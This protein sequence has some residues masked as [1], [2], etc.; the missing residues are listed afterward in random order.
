MDMIHIYLVHLR[1]HLCMFLVLSWHLDLVYVLPPLNIVLLPSTPHNPNA[2][3]HTQFT[4]LVR[5][6]HPGFQ[7]TV[8]QLNDPASHPS[9]L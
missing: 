6:A 3:H 2:S 4:V 8:S 9:N 1:V 5:I 7:R